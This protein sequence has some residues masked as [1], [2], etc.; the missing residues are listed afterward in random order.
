MVFCFL[1]GYT[2][3]T[4]RAWRLIMRNSLSTL[5]PAQFEAL[6]LE[7]DS[8]GRRRKAAGSL[9]AGSYTIDTASLTIPGGILTR[10]DYQRAPGIHLSPYAGMAYMGSKAGIV[11]P[12]L[13]RHM[14]DALSAAAGSGLHLASFLNPGGLKD[15]DAGKAEVKLKCPKVSAT[16]S[17]V[18]WR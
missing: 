6:R 10:Q 11:G 8:E 15:L 12:H 1:I 14:V 7:V 5:S 18:D 13:V 3:S 9:V 2:D 16:R 4:Q 17:K